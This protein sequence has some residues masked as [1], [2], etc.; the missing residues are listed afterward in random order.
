MITWWWV[1]HGPTYE[2]AFVGWRDVPADLSDTQ[3][4]ARVANALPTDAALVSS[5]LIRA[6]ATAD[7]ISSGQSRLPHSPALREIDFGIWDGKRFDEVAATHPDLSRDFW[8]RPGDVT[9]PNGE[10]WN[11]TSRRVGAFVDAIN[12]TPPSR[13]II[14]VAHFGVILT[15]VQR[16]LDISPYDALS[17]RIDNLSITTL[18]FDGASWS[19]EMINHIL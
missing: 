19:A 17:H 9:A 13:H 8:E 10:S 14:A 1:R 4:I 12:R 18:A 11:D 2:S 7:A 6:T 5:D 15:Q 16:A 3:M